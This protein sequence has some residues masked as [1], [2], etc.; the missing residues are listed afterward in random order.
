MLWSWNSMNISGYKGLNFYESFMVFETPANSH[1]YTV[2]V[3]TPKIILKVWTDKGL[4]SMSSW[5]LKLYQIFST[6]RLSKFK[7]HESFLEFELINFWT[8]WIFLEFFRVLARDI[9]SKF[10]FHI[11][12]WL[13]SNYIW[14]K[15]IRVCL[16][17]Y[18]TQLLHQT[19][20][21]DHTCTWIQSPKA[22]LVKG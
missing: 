6:L 9:L 19:F 7:L 2:K 22:F 21:Q 13:L 3:W 14:N 17:V 16:F 12:K 1:T 5:S 11:N 4:N 8:S 18:N 15:G 20:P 10:Y